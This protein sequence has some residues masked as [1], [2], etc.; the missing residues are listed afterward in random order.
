MSL[1]SILVV[2]THIQ[3]IVKILPTLLLLT[4]DISLCAVKRRI[5]LAFLPLDLLVA[6]LVR[7]L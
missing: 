2:F 4:P 6:N 1:V 7:H 5:T 3:L